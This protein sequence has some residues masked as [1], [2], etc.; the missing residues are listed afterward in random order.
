MVLRKGTWSFGRAQASPAAIGGQGPGRG[1]DS[2]TDTNRRVFLGGLA[3][4]AGGLVATPSLAAGTDGHA[5][6]YD[7]APASDY[8]PLIARRTGEP[9]TFTASLDRLPLKA[10]SG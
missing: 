8:V 2:M 9:V 1:I 6:G 5:A 7:V 4:A 10:T 3:V